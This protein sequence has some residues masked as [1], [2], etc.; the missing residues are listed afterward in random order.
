VLRGA[1]SNVTERKKEEIMKTKSII[2]SSLIVLIVLFVGAEVKAQTEVTE[3][4]TSFF[5]VTSAKTLPWGTDGTYTSYEA[6]GTVVTDT[7]EGLF[8]NATSQ[9]L[10]GFLMGKGDVEASGYYVYTVKDGEKIFVKSSGS[11]KAQD[12]DRK[13]TSRIVGGTGKYAGIEGQIEGSMYNLGQSPQKAYFISILFK[14][15]V[16]YKLP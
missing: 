6:F 10:A 16:R 8:H 13:I 5:Y 15:K 9:G 14:G 2:A 12:P 11:K 4:I 3:T 1:E 7:G